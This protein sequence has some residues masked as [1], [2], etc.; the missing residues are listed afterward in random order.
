MRRCE[1]CYWLC[2]AAV[3]NERL[4]VGMLISF[5]FQKSIIVLKKID[6]FS[7]IEF[8]RRSLSRYA[9]GYYV[10][11]HAPCSMHRVIAISHCRS[12]GALQREFKAQADGL[13]TS[14]VCYC[15][16]RRSL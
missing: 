14:A 7:I 16:G 2:P 5:F 6:F 11:C 13:G 15:A 3:F 8:G 9:V 10:T 12:V 4:V 1:R